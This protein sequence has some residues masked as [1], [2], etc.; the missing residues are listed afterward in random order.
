MG[1]IWIIFILLLE[2][3]IIIIKITITK[4]LKE[5]LLIWKETKLIKFLDPFLLSKEITYRDDT[6]S[7]NINE[8]I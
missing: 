7:I 1:W 3:V 5:A 8:T 6:E 2:E 4:Y